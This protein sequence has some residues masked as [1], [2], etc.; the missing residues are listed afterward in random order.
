MI[1][2]EIITLLRLLNL[3]YFIVRCCIFHYY[4]YEGHNYNEVFT[5]HTVFQEFFKL[6]L[7]SVCPQNK[8]LT[9][10]CTSSVTDAPVKIN[11]K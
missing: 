4:G 9:V 8:H 5:S 7:A 1:L 10:L 3:K 11:I 2:S 6:L